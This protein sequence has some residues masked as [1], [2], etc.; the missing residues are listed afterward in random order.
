MLPSLFLSRALHRLVRESCERVTPASLG[1]PR[2]P[3]EALQVHAVDEAFHVSVEQSEDVVD[4]VAWL[5]NDVLSNFVDLQVTRAYLD[6]RIH[7]CR[8]QVH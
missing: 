1:E 4:V 3:D 2:V 6:A 5:E 7:E 8:Q